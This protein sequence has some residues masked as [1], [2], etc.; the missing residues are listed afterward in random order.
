[1]TC[2]A[3]AIAAVTVI[4]ML[5]LGGVAAAH[6]PG[7]D[8]GPADR[9]CRPVIHRQFYVGASG[10]VGCW[11]ARHVASSVIRGH[12]PRYW[13]CTYLR[14]SRGFGHC[15]GRGPLLGW[16]VHWAVND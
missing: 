4:A 1:M 14:P 9:G 15:H 2:R 13:R 12:H 10:G 5:I 6:L 16:T 7:T 11:V 8:G 3:A